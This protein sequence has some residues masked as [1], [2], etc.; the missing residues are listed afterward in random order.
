VIVT[1]FRVL[2][3]FYLSIVYLIRENVYATI[4]L[5]IAK[6]TLFAQ[7]SIVLFNIMSSF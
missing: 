1:I 5:V 6:M 7:G 4:H 3:R 2:P